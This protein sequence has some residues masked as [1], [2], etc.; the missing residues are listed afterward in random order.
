VKY[1]VN[2]DEDEDDESEDELSDA[3]STDEDANQAVFEVVRLADFSVKEYLVSSRVLLG[4]ASAFGVQKE[5]PHIHLAKSCLR[6]IRHYDVVMSQSSFD[7]F[8]EESPLIY[9]ASNY[10]PNY[11]RLSRA[12]RLCDSS[13]SF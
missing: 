10:W 1:W 12:K 7:D 6:H 5:N 2:F 9:Y 4:S 11:A 3:E 13:A 8:I